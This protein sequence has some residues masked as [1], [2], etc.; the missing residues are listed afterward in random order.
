ML[1][2]RGMQALRTFIHDEAQA[3]DRHL[4]GSL[5]PSSEQLDSLEDTP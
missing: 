2:N 5:Q 1:Y 3:E 4:V